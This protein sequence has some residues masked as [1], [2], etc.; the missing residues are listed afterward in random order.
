MAK[1]SGKKNF[2][3][4]SLEKLA[5]RYITAKAAAACYQQDVDAI[6][7]EVVRRSK[8]RPHLFTSEHFTMELGYHPQER[9]AAKEAFF[10]AF[11]IGNLRRRKLIKDIK[12]CT[13]DVKRKKGK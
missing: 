11:G 7:A 8:G 9:L 12:V 2:K 4:H 13:L 10:K 1:L 5:E 3:L 6:K